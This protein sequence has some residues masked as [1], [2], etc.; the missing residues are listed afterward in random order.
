MV[1]LSEG[2]TFWGEL[3]DEIAPVRDAERRIDIKGTMQVITGVV[4]G[5]VREH[6]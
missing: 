3:T 5:W 2:N 4:E 6:P 1:R